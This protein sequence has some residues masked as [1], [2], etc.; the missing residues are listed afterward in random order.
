MDVKRIWILTWH[1]MDHVS[2]SLGLFSKINHLLEVGL[3]QNWETTALWT[4]T[5]V[6][7]F[8]F[9]MCEDMYEFNEIAFGWGS[10]HIWLHTRLE[11]LWPHYYMILE[12]CW[13]GLWTLSFGLSQCHGH[14][15]WL[16]CEVALSVGY[17]QELQ[18]P[19][20]HSLFLKHNIK[21]LI[22]IKKNDIDCPIWWGWANSACGE[23]M[24]LESKV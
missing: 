19:L 2:W 1:R 4:F 11:D 5:T 17:H 24:S 8:Y 12:V 22:Q 6:D 16:V 23:S 14:G 21:F 18:V 10:C 9:I 20:I 7:L 13:N 3:I 15:S